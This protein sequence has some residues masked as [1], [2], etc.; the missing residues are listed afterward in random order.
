MSFGTV[1]V[2]TCQHLLQ[3]LGLPPQ[4]PLSIILGF[5]V[6]PH[7]PEITVAQSVLTE[8]S[9]S[10]G[11][12]LQSNRTRSDFFPDLH[13]FCFMCMSGFAHMYVYVSCLP[14]VHGGQKRA[15]DPL[16]LELWRKVLRTKSRSSASAGSALDDW[17][18][19]PALSC[20]LFLSL[21]FCQPFI[22]VLAVV[23]THSAKVL[24]SVCEHTWGNVTYTESRSILD[25]PGVSCVTGHKLNVNDSIA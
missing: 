21:Y 10:H 22:S 13:F 4:N 7:S 25:L 18:L 23:L 14:G 19:P 16:E 1:P 5:A 15:S 9:S 8:L 24:S 11:H 2:V 17:T 6:N 20:I 3:Y 12:K